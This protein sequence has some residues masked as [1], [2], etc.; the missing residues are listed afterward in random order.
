MVPKL[1]RAIA[2]GNAAAPRRVVDGIKS[3]T[4][5]DHAE[6]KR[7]RRQT[8]HGWE[9]R[10]SS[11]HAAAREPQFNAARHRPGRK[12]SGAA[13]GPTQPS[14]TIAYLTRSKP[15]TGEDAEDNRQNSAAMPDGRVEWAQ[16][17]FDGWGHVRC[18]TETGRGPLKMTA[19]RSN[20]G[21]Q[22]ALRSPS[23]RLSNEAR[24]P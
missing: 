20:C 24:R 9:A 17:V 19:D 10:R 8:R 22:A 15:G 14:C 11:R 23:A 3:L 7:S 2:I 5:D 16:F 4:R 21:P 13:D 1:H 6:G 18:S 12:G